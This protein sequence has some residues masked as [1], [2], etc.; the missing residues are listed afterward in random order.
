MI[1]RNITQAIKYGLTLQQKRPISTSALFE[2]GKYHKDQH[3]QI[4]TSK[5]EQDKYGLKESYGAYPDFGRTHDRDASGGFVGRKIPFEQDRKQDTSDPLVR[6]VDHGDMT[7][8][9]ADAFKKII[10]QQDEGFRALEANKPAPRGTDHTKFKLFEPHADN[11]RHT[12]AYFMKNV[13]GRDVFARTIEEQYS[14][15]QKFPK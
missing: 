9:Q 15:S 4:T 13:L 10:A 11:C 1:R 5:L 6:T 14:N 7:Q 2:P 8:G 3:I 12:H